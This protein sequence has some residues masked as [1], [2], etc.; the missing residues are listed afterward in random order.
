M[1][2]NKCFRTAI[3]KEL[4]T[5]RFRDVRSQSSGSDISASESDDLG[6]IIEIDLVNLPDLFITTIENLI[7]KERPEIVVLDDENRNPPEQG[8]QSS[9]TLG[10]H[11]PN[12]SDNKFPSY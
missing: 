12:Y 10:S 4:N 2:I 8:I 3:S 1:S 5:L 11:Y 9:C 6:A 7:K